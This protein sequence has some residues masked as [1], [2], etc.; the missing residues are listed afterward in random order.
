MND[1]D[2][3]P[4]VIDVEEFIS[5]GFKNS[6]ESGIYSTFFVFLIFLTFPLLYI[7]IFNVDCHREGK[8]LFEN[9]ECYNLLER[10]PCFEESMWLV[11][12]V[13]VNILKINQ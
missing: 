4:A 12:T 10:G 5:V 9:G 8:V 11:M 3:I 13:E 7:L 1:D 6:T 2:D